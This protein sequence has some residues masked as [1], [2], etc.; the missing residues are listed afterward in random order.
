MLT[1]TAN[2]KLEH[3]SG[4]GSLYV[5]AESRRSLPSPHL[6]RDSN[7]RALEGRGVVDTIARHAHLFFGRGRQRYQ[8][9]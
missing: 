1:L 6:D 7:V 9:I 3:P 2:K 4:N 5:Q 8:R